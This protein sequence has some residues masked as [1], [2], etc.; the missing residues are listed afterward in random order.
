LSSRSRADRPLEGAAER[1][2]ARAE[3]AERAAQAVEAAAA[4]AETDAARAKEQSDAVAAVGANVFDS[5]GVGMAAV[6]AAEAARKAAAAERVAAERV[7]FA[8]YSALLSARSLQKAAE[9]HRGL[10]NQGQ[11]GRAASAPARRRRSDTGC[12][13]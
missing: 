4:Q 10:S 12:G 1:A 5:P 8:A 2:A 13:V 3:A 6:E 9:E 11:P 7:K